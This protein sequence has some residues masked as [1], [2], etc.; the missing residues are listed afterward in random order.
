MNVLSL[1]DGISCGYLALKKV[2]IDVD[3]YWASEIE[4]IMLLN[5]P[6]LSFAKKK[7]PALR[8]GIFSLVEVRG[9]ALASRLGH[10]GSG[11]PLGCHSLPL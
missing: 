5:F 11:S 1:F 4:P 8:L 10:R 2:G 9:I 7:H 6:Y 3:K